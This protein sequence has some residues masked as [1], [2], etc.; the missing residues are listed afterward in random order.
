MSEASNTAAPLASSDA[1]ATEQVVCK[2][3]ES[4]ASALQ[5]L[6]ISVL[7][8]TYQAGRVIVA[9]AEN[10]RQVNLAHRLLPSPMGIAL[11]N[12]ALAIGT[13]H[14]IH[15]YGNNRQLSAHLDPPG[16]HDVVFVPTNSKFTGDVR[17]HEM[18]YLGDELW[19]A[20]THFSCLATMSGRYSFVPQWRPPFISKLAPE[21][22]CHLNG[23]AV[24]D[25]RIAYVTALGTTDSYQGWRPDKAFGGVIME[26]PS[27][28]VVVDGL[29]MPHSPRWH[30][31]R[32]W[33]LESGKGSLAYIDEHG[34]P[35]TVIELPGFTRGLGF[36]GAYAFIGMS[37]VRESNVFGGIPL[38]SRVKEKQC[39]VAIVDLRDGRCVA[40]LRF[41]SGVAEV[42]DVQLIRARWPELCDFNSPLVPANF[43][44]PDE[45]LKDVAV[46]RQTSTRPFL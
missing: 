44:V 42:F 15:E 9:R 37:K 13:H 1:P 8:S 22:R 34:K 27:G 12:R 38:N 11:S 3:T 26:V 10:E 28:R 21:D 25:G 4:F 46:K 40:M 6:G 23:I 39:G 14:Q 5:Q 19:F 41:E 7:I 45:A 33:V 32:L 31:N 35:Q 17:V 29:S 24:K 43:F 16:K 36:A 30:R 20:N 18:V 2:T